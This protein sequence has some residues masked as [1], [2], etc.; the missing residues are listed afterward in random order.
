MS[1][2]YI[3]DDIII[4]SEGGQVMMEWEKPYMEA[5][6]DTLQPTGDVLEIGFGLGYSATQIMTYNPKSYTI[7]ECNSIVINKVKEWAK[8]YPSISIT[9]VEGKWQDC[10]THL[11]IFDQ[12]YFDDYPLN[13][14]KHS[15][16][17]ERV[18][19]F[20]RLNLFTALC[21][22]NHT[23]VGSKISWYLNGNPKKMVFGSDTMPF[24]TLETTPFP[25]HIPET[26]KYRNIKDHQCTIPL[27]TKIKECDFNEAQRL[28]LNHIETDR[29]KIKF[30]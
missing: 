2:K 30:L 27:L 6:I 11:G 21:I 28:A 13:I 22:Q 9:I 3:E 4:T 19:S 7:I 20:T 17:K 15:S 10:L 24:I 18:C 12:I 25:I 8:K 23:H 14:T 16:F 1:L 5:S 26:C 29:A